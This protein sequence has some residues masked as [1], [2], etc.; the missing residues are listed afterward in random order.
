MSGGVRSART[1]H[2]RLVLAVHLVACSRAPGA[3][4]AT[5]A[6]ADQT[7]LA[8]DCSSAKLALQVLGS[9]GP[10]P[11][12]ARASSG[13]LIWK[14]GA[15]R[16][17][18]DAGGGV[19]QRFGAAQASLDDLE[20]I[21]LTHLHADHSSDLAALLKG[22]YFT[23]R[24]AALPLVGPSGNADFPSVEEY[25]R[26]LLSP[27]SGAYRYLSGYVTN[28]RGWFQLLPRRIDAGRRHPEDVL[29]TESFQV[30][31]VGVEHGSVPAVAYVFE[32]GN[33][34]I[35][36]AGD[37][38]GNN[39]AFVSLARDADLLIM[40]H[41]VPEKADPVLQKLHAIPSQIGKVA[42]AARVRRLVLSHHMKRA[43]DRLEEGLDAIRRNYEGP[44]E[45]AG[46]LS[47]YALD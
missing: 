9:G 20:V 31:A 10:I 38:S 1:L 44:V 41:A 29:S 42:Q 28:Q 22:A 24:K 30:R 39:P 34:R 35:A 11:D 46:D 26:L 19:F 43:L 8:S 7:A 27:E 36:I 21:A 13:Y 47:C 12:D 37:Q 40:H 14:D 32:V 3:G 45:I 4:P 25:V 15:S 18:V 23:S 17:L 2:R 5:A 16:A 33:R 6:P